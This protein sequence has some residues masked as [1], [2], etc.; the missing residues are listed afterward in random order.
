MKTAARFTAT[1]LALMAALAP[2]M[3][4]AQ[5]AFPE[6]PVR[7]IVTFP[8]GG[9]TDI[10]GRLIAAKMGEG[11]GKPVLVENKPGA[12]GNI[13]TTEAA[14][15]AAD[16]Y[17]LLFHIVTTAVINPLTQKNLSYDP[18]RDLAPVAMIARIPNV[19]IV[20][21]D[22]PAKNLGELIALLK[23]N[24]GKYNYGSSGTG[25]LMHLSGELFKQQ[26]GIDVQHIPYKGSAPAMQ[27]MMA[28]TIAYMF[29]N[30][31]GAMVRRSG[32]VRLFG[33]TTEQR[34]PIAPEVPSIAEAG[35]PQFKNASWFSLFT[36]A[37]VP[38]PV[39]ARLEAEAL[40]AINH[41]ETAERLKTLGA[42]PAPMGAAQLDKFWKAEFD[43]WR[44]VVQSVK[45]D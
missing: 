10:V 43:Y 16:G 26:A 38:A 2:G 45:L 13:G 18:V 34:V 29:D 37:G 42:I 7:L 8:P 22:L 33:V 20:N 21:K 17:T 39:L 9:S 14:K 44:P 24:P 12:A 31:T 41:P 27:E 32:Q 15:S 30:I 11:L 36:R 40:K 5:G 28:G 25:G 1:A 35:L 6:R 3:T 19:L 23:A 4:L